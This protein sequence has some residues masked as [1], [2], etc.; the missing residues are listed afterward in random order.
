[1]DIV[2]DRELALCLIITQSMSAVVWATFKHEF[3][4]L[5]KTT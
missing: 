5:Q 3:S 4:A 1:M 2:G